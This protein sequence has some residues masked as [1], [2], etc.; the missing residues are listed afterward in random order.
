MALINFVTGLAATALFISAHVNAS[1]LL[2]HNRQTSQCT[3]GT[4]S[5]VIMPAGVSISVETAVSVSNGNYGEGSSDQGFPA[6]A[7]GLPS[8]CAVIISVTNTSAVPQSNYR[9]GM[10][11]PDTWNSKVLTVGSASFAGGINWPAMGEVRCVLRRCSI[12][13]LKI[14]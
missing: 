12:K 4:F 11:L 9:F 14:S 3:T 5:G 7:F 10:F 6:I 1:H 8:L 13:T 2:K